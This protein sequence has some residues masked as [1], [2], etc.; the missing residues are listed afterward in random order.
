MIR[1]LFKCPKYHAVDFPSDFWLEN[2]E[3]N[4]VRINCDW[5]KQYLF[6]YPRIT[7]VAA[8]SG[9][10]IT[11]CHFYFF[12]FPHC[13]EIRA[14]PPTDIP[15]RYENRIYFKYFSFFYYLTIILTY[16]FTNYCK[17]TI[18]LDTIKS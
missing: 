13:F 3:Q 17:S 5:I 4:W 15:S 16:I 6:I 12:I 14:T 7:T 8:I 2:G 11:S 1:E 18:I 10:Q 9:M